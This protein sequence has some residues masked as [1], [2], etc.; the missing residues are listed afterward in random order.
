MRK[1]IQIA[2]SSEENSADIVYAL[3]DD[4]SLWRVNV[5]RSARSHDWLAM[6]D[7]PQDPIMEANNE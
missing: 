1:I 2:V 4:G 3:A 5:T 7:L 6:P